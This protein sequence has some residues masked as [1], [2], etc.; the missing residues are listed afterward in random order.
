MQTLNCL[1][2]KLINSLLAILFTSSTIA[3][4]QVRDS[5]NNKIKHEASIDFAAFYTPILSKNI[6]GV[7]I[8]F[9]YYP[10][11]KIATGFCISMTTTEKK[12]GDTFSYSIGQPVIEYYEFGW[13]NQYD[14]L[15]SHQEVL[16]CK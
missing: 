4:G 15:Q 9:K 11:K 1:K 2:M 16:G 6:Y 14:F 3:Y 7:N 5:L 10:T 13:I 12:I 8:D